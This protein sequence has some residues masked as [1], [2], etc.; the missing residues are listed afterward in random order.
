MVGVVVRVRV[1]VRQTGRGRGRGRGRVQA[2]V[3]VRW[4]RCTSRGGEITRGLH[5]FALRIGLG[6]KGQG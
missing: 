4:G 1:R 5:R 3:M 2:R 6:C